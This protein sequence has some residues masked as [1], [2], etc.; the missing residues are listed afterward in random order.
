MDIF[1]DRLNIIEYSLS[2][3]VNMMY[4]KCQERAACNCGVA[5]K[6]GDTVFVA[7]KCRRHSVVCPDNSPYCNGEE[8]R[9]RIF[10]HGHV[11]PPHMRIFSRNAGNGFD[12]S[13][14]S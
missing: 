10:T 5:V 12:V 14:L 6:S 3:Q 9:T 8:M 11:T 7:E 1:V 4:Q 2:R 13:C